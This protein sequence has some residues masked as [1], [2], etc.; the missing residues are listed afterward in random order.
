MSSN[1]CGSI[2]RCPKCKSAIRIPN[3]PESEL[4]AGEMT[5]CTAK[6]ATRK[7]DDSLEKKDTECR[8]P[9]P[10]LARSSVRRWRT[11]LGSGE[12][13]GDPAALPVPSPVVPV[14]DLQLSDTRAPNL[15]E[16]RSWRERLET[17]NSSRKI[18]AKLFAA[19]LCFM[20]IVNMVPALYHWH[21]WSQVAESMPLSRWIYI[22]F[23]VG[24]VHLICAI[25]L[26]RSPTWSAMRA[27]SIMMLAMAFVFGF[28]S[29]GLLTGGGEGNLI[30]FLEIPD[31]LYRHACIWCVA[32]LCLTTLMSYWG[33]KESTRWERVDRLLKDAVTK[34]ST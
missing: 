34:A 27:V 12:P 25:F 15:S 24:A 22:Q 31:A 7:T 20:A 32:M 17:A 21:H 4:V 9:V 29:T 6:I 16:N 18:L 2:V 26:L 33:G 5:S 28:V 14:T 11:D 13:S 1:R 8:L 23:F 19:V 3:V 30:G 10:K